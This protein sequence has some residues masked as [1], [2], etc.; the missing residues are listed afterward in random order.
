METITKTYTIG[1]TAMPPSNY[2]WICPKCGKV[3]A[4][5]VSECNCH[6][7]TITVGDTPNNDWWKTG[8]GDWWKTLPRYDWKHEVTCEE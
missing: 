7:N 6:Q 5:W 8:D 2:G 4:P 3:N 1:D